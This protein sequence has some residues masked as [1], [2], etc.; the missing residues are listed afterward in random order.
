MY[1]LQKYL[2]E[3]QVV[4]EK[5]PLDKIQEVIDTLNEARYSGQHIFTMGNG[6]SASTASHFVCDLGKNTR[7]PGIPPFKVIGL[8]DNI[9]TLT[10]YANDEG[11]ENIFAQQL[12]SLA[13]PGDVVIGISTSGRSPNVLTAMQV[14]QEVGAKTIGFTG[15]D[16][17]VLGKM[18]DIHVNV[19]NDCVE[20]I[21]DVH[22]M[23]EHLISVTLRDEYGQKA[24]TQ[25]L[26]H[27]L[28]SDLVGQL[29]QRAS[30]R[31]L[32]QHS[33]DRIGASSGSLL[34]IDEKGDVAEGI[35]AYSGKLEA[36]AARE[37]AEI[38]ER[39]LARWVIENRRAALVQN[40]HEDPR[41]LRRKW[42]DGASRSAISIPLVNNG[43][44]IGVLTL[45]HSRAGQFTNDDLGDVQKMIELE[46]TQ[47]FVTTFNNV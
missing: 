36:M 23:L 7:Q 9:A 4:L 37:F 17:G 33:L 31:S 24:A 22:L 34:V 44:L 40:T 25:L 35:M 3:L 43:H 5:L 26:Y 42:E 15:F 14:A 27:K 30:F 20:Q 19:P 16:G 21:E 2:I 1:P 28:E 41:W 29:D 11:Y 38:F 32:L 8:A 45:V 10:A 47:L 13:A 46:V 18:V 6:G 39:G 12:S